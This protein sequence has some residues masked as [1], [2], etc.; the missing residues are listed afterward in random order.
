VSLRRLEL[1]TIRKHTQDP[2]K[3]PLRVNSFII[4]SLEESLDMLKTQ[5]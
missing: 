3:L 4:S 2:S 1:M 5:H